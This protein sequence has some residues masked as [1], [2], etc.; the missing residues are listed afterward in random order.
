MSEAPPALIGSWLHSYEEDTTST[1]V[2]R[3]HNYPFRLSRRPRSGLEFRTDGTFLEGQPGPD[4]RL[5]ETVGHW[6]VQGPNRVRITFPQG[7][8][9]PFELAILSCTHEVL[10]LAK[11]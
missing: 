11:N 9:T 5:Q 2:Y 6:E 7:S 10:T 1:S 4:D 8:R 3:S